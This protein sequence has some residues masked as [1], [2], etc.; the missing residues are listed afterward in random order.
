MQKGFPICFEIAALKVSNIIQNS[1]KLNT[2]NSKFLVETNPTQALISSYF[3]KTTAVV[4]EPE[5]FLFFNFTLLYVELMKLSIFHCV[6]KLLL[7]FC[8]LDQ[9]YLETS[10]TISLQL[11]EKLVLNAIKSE[12]KCSINSPGD[13]VIISD[14][15]YCFVV[16]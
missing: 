11:G 6:L 9:K 12:Q 8:R 10:L 7:L 13:F 16:Q 14:L 5:G 15:Q 2:C 3:V 1:G 4:H